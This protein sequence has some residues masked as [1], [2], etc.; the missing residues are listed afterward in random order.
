MYSRTRTAACLHFPLSA[1]LNNWQL[2]RV[3]GAA[4]GSF[5]AALAMIRTAFLLIGPR[6]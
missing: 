3:L 5:G 6:K 2:V 4:A 1:T